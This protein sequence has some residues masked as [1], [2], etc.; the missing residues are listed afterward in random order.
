MSKKDNTFKRDN[1]S[2]IKG[3]K[4]SDLPDTVSSDKEK[5]FK[6]S[7]L[8]NKGKGSNENLGGSLAD[9][10]SMEKKKRRLI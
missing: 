3:K 8:R 6:K 9:Q 5:D 1:K 10:K 2:V 7:K 4:K